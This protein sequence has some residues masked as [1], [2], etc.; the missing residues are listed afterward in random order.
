MK[1][2]KKRGCVGVLDSD[3]RISLQVKRIVNPVPMALGRVDFVKN[4]ADYDCEYGDWLSPH[5]V[6]CD[7]D[8]RFEIADGKR[9]VP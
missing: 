9:S 1:R 8:L 7:A 3:N 2:L 4:A 6:G 5:G